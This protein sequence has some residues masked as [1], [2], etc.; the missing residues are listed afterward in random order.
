[1]RLKCGCGYENGVVSLCR[2]GAIKIA[3]AIFGLGLMV[4][5]IVARWQ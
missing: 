4:E 2:A 3:V 5:Y 1:M